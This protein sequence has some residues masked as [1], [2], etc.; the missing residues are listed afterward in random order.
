M[1]TLEIESILKR[2]LRGVFSGVYAED[3]L[4]PIVLR[5]LAMVINTDPSSLP[6]RHW[7]A[8]YIDNSGYGQ[9]FDT[10]G[11]P[12]DRPVRSYLNK[13]APRG[14]VY[15][16]RRIQSSI[17]TICGMYCVEWLITRHR[18]PRISFENLLNKLYPFED[19][20]LNDVETYRRFQELYGDKKRPLID[21]R[22]LM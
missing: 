15:N 5:P 19:S 3:E 7:T 20:W 16:R 11:L 6:G 2:R 10:R 8:V 14:Y 9:F 21:L 12:P 4:P 22:Y 18:N 17:S 13:K 1:D